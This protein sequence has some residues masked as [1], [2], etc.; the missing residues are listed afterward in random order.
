MS[1]FEPE[2]W[3]GGAIV[4]QDFDV[5]SHKANVEGWT[6]IERIRAG[7]GELRPFNQATVNEFRDNDSQILP[8]FLL[9][10]LIYGW[11]C[12]YIPYTRGTFAYIS[13][14]GYWCINTETDMDYQQLQCK[15]AIYEADH[16]LSKQRLRNPR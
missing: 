3:S 13:H 6:M 14:D 12:F 16:W 11:D 5:W 2:N 10:P 1:N 7:Y 8:A 4:Y 9:A 15:L